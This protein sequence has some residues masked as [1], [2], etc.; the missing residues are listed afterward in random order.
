[1]I[2]EIL[3]HACYTDVILFTLAVLVFIAGIIIPVI[4]YIVN[5]IETEF[6]PTWAD[7]KLYE[8]TKERYDR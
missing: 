5:V 4:K 8:E 6:C 3:E 2:T 7:R 1:M